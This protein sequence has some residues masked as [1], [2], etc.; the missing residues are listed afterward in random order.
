MY[1]PDACS[2]SLTSQRRSQ[3]SWRTCSPLPH[4]RPASAGLMHNAARVARKGWGRGRGCNSRHHEHTWPRVS[5]SELHAPGCSCM[6]PRSPSHHPSHTPPATGGKGIRGLDTK[7]G[8][9]FGSCWLVQ[10]CNAVRLQGLSD[11][12]RGSLLHCQCKKTAGRRCEDAIWLH[13][14][15]PFPPPPTHT[16]GCCC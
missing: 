15:P 13:V 12:A 11:C 16:R 14:A 6:L 10:L 8:C 5:L 9:R 3:L 2:P 4:P 7:P 1:C